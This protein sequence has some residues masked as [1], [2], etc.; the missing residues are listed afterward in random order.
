MFSRI[1]AQGKAV[2]INSDWNQHRG[3]EAYFEGHPYLI[4]RENNTC[5]ILEQPGNYRLLEH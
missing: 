3:T 1:D 5:G 2:L 4:K